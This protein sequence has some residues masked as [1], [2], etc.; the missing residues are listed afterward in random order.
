MNI[1]MPGAWNDSWDDPEPV[2]HELD[3]SS[4]PVETTPHFIST[5]NWISL[6][7]AVPLTHELPSPYFES[8]EATQEHYGYSALRRD[9]GYEDLEA[10]PTASKP[11]SPDC[12]DTNDHNDTIEDNSPTIVIA[13]FGQTGTGKTS[14]I[15][16]V[17]GKDL[18][19]GHDLTSCKTF[20]SCHQNWKH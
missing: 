18:Q 12:S 15:K 3:G 13:V 19:V 11:Q 16:A 8:T 5:Q 10:P 1:S 14:L 17:T 2:I 6:H 9:S 4:M 7:E 20:S